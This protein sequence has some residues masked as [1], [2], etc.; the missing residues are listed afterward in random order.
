MLSRIVVLWDLS[1][2]TVCVCVF[3]Q[4]CHSLTSVYIANIE[5]VFLCR[6]ALC[7]IGIR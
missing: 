7:N 1:T 2:V 4:V 3:Y 5:N 6:G